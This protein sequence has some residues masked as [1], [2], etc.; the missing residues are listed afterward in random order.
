M[1][2][3][4]R[5]EDGSR[6]CARVRGP[7]CEG[8][9]PCWRGGGGVSGHREWLAASRPHHPGDPET[10]GIYALYQ[11]GV[12]KHMGQSR[13]MRVPGAEAPDARA[14]LAGAQ[15]LR[16]LLSLPTR[17]HPDRSQWETVTAGRV[18]SGTVVI[19][20]KQI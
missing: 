1:T 5:R 20:W 14:G 9:G 4:G 19:G 12:L 2:G 16:T 17:H 6:G 8:E 3:G 13:Q 18:C 10:P 15:T 7:P 11:G